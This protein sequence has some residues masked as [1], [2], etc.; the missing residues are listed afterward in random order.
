MVRFTGTGSMV[1]RGDPPSTDLV[2]VEDEVELADVLEALVQRLHK[3]CL[4]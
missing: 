4:F 1:R 2:A 3:H